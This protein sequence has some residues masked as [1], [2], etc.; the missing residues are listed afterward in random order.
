MGKDI[1]LSEFKSCIEKYVDFDYSYINSVLNLI[2]EVR[3]DLYSN[4]NLNLLMDKFIIKME[5]I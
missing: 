2:I 5:A 4:V 1:V 3:D